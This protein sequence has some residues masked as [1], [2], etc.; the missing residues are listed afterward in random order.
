MGKI[1]SLYDPLIVIYGLRKIGHW[2]FSFYYLINFLKLDSFT[3]IS[4]F[5]TVDNK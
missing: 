2:L 1:D 3:L 5:N 4:Y